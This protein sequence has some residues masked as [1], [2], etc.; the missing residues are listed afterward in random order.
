MDYSIVKKVFDERIK[1]ADDDEYLKNANILYRHE[2]A[3][4]YS[5]FSGDEGYFRE[6][7]EN[8]SSF[9]GTCFEKQDEDGSM[10]GNV[11]ETAK[12]CAFMCIVSR[13][14]E[15]LDPIFA[16]DSVHVALDAAHYLL[17]SGI[18]LKNLELSEKISMLWA[19]S[20]LSQTDVEIK[21]T[22]DHSLM[23][24]MPQKMSRQK[25]YKMF[26][27]QIL[28]DVLPSLVSESEDKDYAARALQSIDSADFD[29]LMNSLLIIS[30]IDDE[31]F[32]DET[33]SKTSKAI[34]EIADAQAGD[35]SDGDTS[36]RS[37]SSMFGRILAEYLLLKDK[38]I[39][40]SSDSQLIKVIEYNVIN[41]KKKKLSDE[42]KKILNE[43]IERYSKEML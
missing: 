18:D 12:A 7:V 32:G 13:V 33:K 11:K 38:E 29:M 14:Y 5:S 35:G 2:F 30:T 23:A 10:A 34:F 6:L 8:T 43:R 40:E 22:Y 1:K 31:I 28:S 36:A 20:E 26:V 16:R 41:N 21:N 17:V 19:F 9:A 37:L 24:G 27:T 25:K 15:D 4:E 39:E 42:D 3:A